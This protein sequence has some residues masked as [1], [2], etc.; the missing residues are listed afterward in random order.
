MLRRDGLPLAC[1]RGAR[2]YGQRRRGLAHPAHPGRGP[3]ARFCRLPQQLRPCV[4]RHPHRAAQSREYP[5]DLGLNA[6]LKRAL[7][8]DAAE[9]VAGGCINECYRVSAG[10]AS[11]FL[12]LNA[13]SHADA[14]AAEADG[15]RGLQAAGL[16]APMPASH[17]VA[18]GH[19]YLL[20]EYLDLTGPRDF[21]ALGRM[22]A[23]AHRRHGTRFG[24][25]RDNYIGATAQ[26]NAWSETWMQFWRE[27]RLA[28]QL[29]LARANGFHFESAGLD[30][31]LA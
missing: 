18:A 25:R 20:L 31:V 16:R 7:R 11:A 17:G 14:F 23:A 8:I 15:L 13:E 21:A 10:G 9:R 29:A 6:A 12:K 26:D 2:R 5:P 4:H 28:P 22:L 24:W 30:A 3:G 27:R 1:Q 19:A